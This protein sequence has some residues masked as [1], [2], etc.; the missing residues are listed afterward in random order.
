[1]NDIKRHKLSYKIIRKLVTPVF[2]AMFNY[3]F[4][5]VDQVKEPYIVLANHNLELD[6]ALVAMA[7]PQQMYFVASEHIL[8]KGFGGWFLMHILKPIIRMKGKVEVKTVAEILRT[9]R[10]GHNVCIFAEGARSFNGRTC[11]I[12]P[13]TG[14][15]VKRSGSALITYRMEGGYFSQ[16]RWSMSLRKG[17]IQGVVAG[18]YSADE[19]KAMTEDEVNALIVRDLREDAY[20]TQAKDPVPYI[21]KKLA[22]GM[23]STLFLCP[24][25]GQTG[26]MQSDNTSITCSCGAHFTYT[27]YGD[28]I[29]PEG[30]KRSITE[31]DLW[32]QEQLRRRYENAVAASSEEAFF[33]DEV[34]LFAIDENHEIINTKKGTLTAYSDRIECCG[35]NFF[36][37]EMLGLDIFSRNFIVMNYGKD[38]AHYEMKGSLMFCALKY[39]YLYKLVKGETL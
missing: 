7:F 8:R 20:A 16:P 22:L 36:Y 34:T 10:A 19:L 23:E 2:K 13:S 21:G 38:A 26:T 24:K 18:I 4:P 11:N 5:I 32:Q 27:E 31:W 1:M 30:E 35:R 15:M 29:S 39:L 33:S 14:K 12:L 37:E 17:R 25:C 6:P 28:L 3:R 9:A